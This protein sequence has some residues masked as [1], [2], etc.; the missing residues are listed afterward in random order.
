M[1]YLARY[2]RRAV[3]GVKYAKDSSFKKGLHC[4]ETGAEDP[5]VGFDSSPDGDVDEIICG[6]DVSGVTV[7]ESPESRTG[8]VNRI[9]MDGYC[10]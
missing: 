4:G 3:H 8:K 6:G 10:V 2:V 7:E 9:F 1:R 5:S